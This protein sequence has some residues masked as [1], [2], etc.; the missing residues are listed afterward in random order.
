MQSILFSTFGKCLGNVCGIG[1]MNDKLSILFCIDGNNTVT[2]IIAGLVAV[3]FSVLLIVVMTV[4]V[5]QKR[6]KSKL[7][8]YTSGRYHCDLY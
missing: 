4:Y 2:G 8:C 1:S 3:S 5:D 6:K 7:K